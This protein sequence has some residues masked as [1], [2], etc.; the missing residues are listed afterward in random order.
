MTPKQQLLATAFI[1][2]PVNALRIGI[3]VWLDKGKDPSEE[4]LEHHLRLVM[5]PDR[6]TATKEEIT[7][8]GN[9]S[10]VVGK[11]GTA[12][13][14]RVMAARQLVGLEPKPPMKPNK[15]MSAQQKWQGYCESISNAADKCF[16][17][18]KL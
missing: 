4:T 18:L 11:N 6:V 10:W 5:N 2:A 1:L 17:R 8:E 9:P 14:C 7:I 12:R 13:E 3:E 16:A 15:K